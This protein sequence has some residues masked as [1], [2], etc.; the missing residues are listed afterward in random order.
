MA[1]AVGSRRHNPAFC[2]AGATRVDPD[3]D[4]RQGRQRILA[5]PRPVE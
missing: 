5:D 1:V 3:H 4:A 2:F